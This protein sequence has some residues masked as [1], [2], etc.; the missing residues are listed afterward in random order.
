MKISNCA[1][2]VAVALSV[3]LLTAS[4]ANTTSLRLDRS[5]S[6]HTSLAVADGPVPDP[7]LIA[8]SNWDGPVP[9]PKQFI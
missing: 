6:S 1:W 8:A 4:P 3:F 9:D 5:V 7:K 2:L